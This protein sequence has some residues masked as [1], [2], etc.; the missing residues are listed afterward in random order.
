[1]LTPSEALVITDKTSWLGLVNTAST[2]ALM[3]GGS[4]TAWHASKGRRKI[5]A[6]LAVP[7]NPPGI[8]DQTIGEKVGDVAHQTNG[9]LDARIHDG[10]VKAMHEVLTLELPGLV[11]GAI[12]D[13]MADIKP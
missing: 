5:S 13:V 3:V 12:R 6:Q 4:L 8:P 11:R 10:A 7:P 1:M 2:L 9:A